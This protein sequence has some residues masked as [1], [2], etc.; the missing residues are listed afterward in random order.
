MITRKL[1]RPNALKHGVFSA[2][3]ILPG[4]DPEEFEELHSSLIE[5][6]MP[7]GATEED[8]VLSIA[9]AV[10]RKRRVQLFLEVEVRSNAVDPAHPSYQ[11]TLGLWGIGS[12]IELEPETGFQKY[13]DRYLQPERIEFFERKFPRSK[14][15]STSE[16]AAAVLKEIKSLLKPPSI[17]GPEVDQIV[18]LHHSAIPL[19]LFKQELVLDERLDAMI[20]RA[21]K[22]LIQTKAMKEMLGRTSPEARQPKKIAPKKD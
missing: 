3:A 14:F 6:W 1:K 15:K 19:D 16:W 20:D 11:E 2:T 8:A 9:K 5:E 18:N 10:W 12:A 22:R 21:V 7:D 4:E 13:A 17:V